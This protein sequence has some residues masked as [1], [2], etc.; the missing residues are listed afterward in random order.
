[1]TSE[2]LISAGEASGEL[3]AANL[4]KELS[5]LLPGWTAFGMGSGR[6]REAGVRVAFDSA[7]L[8]IMGFSEAL[9]KLMRVR[10]AMRVL[11]DLAVSRAPACAILVDFPDFHMALARRLKERGVRIVYYIPPQVWA[12]RPG[13]AR[14]LARL[15]D[16][17]LVILPFET[18]IYEREGAR[19]RFVGHPL[20]DAG[21]PGDPEGLRRELHAEGSPLISLLP[22]S[23]REE[24]RRHAG[25]F[26]RAAE[27]MERR[28]P[29]AVF[30]AS[31]AASLPRGFC[32]GLFG[33][34]PIVRG[35]T[36]EL[37]TAS[38][39]TVVS[40]GTATLECAILGVPAAV[41]YKTSSLSY[42]IACALVKIKYASLVNILAG[43][44]VVKELIQWKMTP[45]AVADEALR[46]LE[47][48]AREKVLRGYEEVVG[49]LGS[50]GASRRAAEE[51][52]RFVREER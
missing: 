44:E 32:S 23:R 4:W 50:P 20:L 46:L 3:H 48:A 18:S 36:H 17:I 25:V 6:M 19:A 15:A 43:R 1:M 5:S 2:V 14:M 22:G 30:A 51:I 37:L 49:K 27:L 13:R 31:E 42:A 28:A 45:G 11:T 24:V 8:Q 29:G 10:R 21:G 16:L 41:C 7:G 9:P 33:R 40:S 52:A 38:D 34:M 39:A 47:P 12:W 35:R 26:V